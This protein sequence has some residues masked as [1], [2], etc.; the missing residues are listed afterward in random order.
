MVLANYIKSFPVD[1]A[2]G[3]PTVTAENS[4]YGTV[5]YVGRITQ[6]TGEPANDVVIY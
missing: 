6:T 2:T 3:L 4:P 5:D 1:A